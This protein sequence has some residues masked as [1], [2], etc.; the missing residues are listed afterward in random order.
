[1]KFYK[2]AFT[3][4]EADYRIYRDDIPGILTSHEVGGLRP[5]TD[6]VFRVAAKNDLGNGKYSNVL[7]A[8]TLETGKNIWCIS[9]MSSFSPC[10]R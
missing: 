8:Q 6:H 5:Y 1:M 2:L 4:I 10:C 7:A 9:S 3:R